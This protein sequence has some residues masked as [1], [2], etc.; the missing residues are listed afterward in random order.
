MGAVC[1]YRVVIRILGGYSIGKS[2]VSVLQESLATLSYRDR[3][4]Q[5]D[6]N[7]IRTKDNRPTDNIASTTGF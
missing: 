7:R 6:Q 3:H 1:A 2:P 5:I 4:Y